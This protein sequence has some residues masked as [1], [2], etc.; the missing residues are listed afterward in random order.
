MQKKKKDFD[1]KQTLAAARAMEVHKKEM[2]DLK[3]RAER[4]RKEEEIRIQRVEAARNNQQSRVQ[5]IVEKRSQLESHLDVVYHERIKDRT[6]KCV[7]RDV[8]FEEKKANVERIKKVE[9]FNRLQT[10][11][12][13]SQEDSRSRMIKM[14]K[15]ALIEARKKIALESLVRKHRIAEA[16]GNMRISNK[17]D[18]INE[19]MESATTSSPGKDKSRK[20]KLSSSKSASDLETPTYL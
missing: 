12:K 6:L 18:N 20:K 5:T 1:A 4:S 3:A 7:E 8:T 19:I 14:K 17:W 11:L 10:L 16:V 2:L 13:I 9:E 15:Q